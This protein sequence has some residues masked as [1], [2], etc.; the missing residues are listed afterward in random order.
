MSVTHGPPSR[1]CYSTE[2]ELFG[3]SLSHRRP[4]I[5]KRGAGLSHLPSPRA[6][7]QRRPASQSLTATSATAAQS[8]CGP[9]ATAP[10]V[11]LGERGGSA[12]KDRE[13]LKSFDLPSVP[14]ARPAQGWGGALQSQNLNITR[15]RFTGNA[16]MSGG[17]ISSVGRGLLLVTNST[18]VNNTASI[19]GGAVHISSVGQA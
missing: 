14:C 12:V 7:G 6:Q 19:S 18:L 10:S 9:N 17:A 13:K 2:T 1:V 5:S 4:A 3:V 8:R 15:C 16:A 11:C